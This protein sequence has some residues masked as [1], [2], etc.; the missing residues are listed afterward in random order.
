[1]QRDYVTITPCI[2]NCSRNASEQSRRAATE[3]RL[4]SLPSPDS[5]FWVWSDGSADESVSMGGVGALILLPGGEKREL[6]VPAGRLCSSTHAELIAL[7]AAV[8]G[9]HGPLAALPVVACLDSRAALLLL[10]GGPAT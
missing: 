1:M 3:K 9:L 6:R 4:D 7:R 8:R 10:D 2:D 5:A